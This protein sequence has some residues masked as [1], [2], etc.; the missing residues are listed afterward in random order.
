MRFVRIKQ[1]DTELIYA[2]MGLIYKHDVLLK[3]IHGEEDEEVNE[4]YLKD[5]ETM[6]V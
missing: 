2:Q 5:S 6:I 1:Q 3:G 4:R